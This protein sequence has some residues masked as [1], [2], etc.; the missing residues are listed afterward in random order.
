MKTLLTLVFI[1][2][3]CSEVFQ[4]SE[5]LRCYQCEGTTCDP[6]TVTCSA[7]EDTCQT[8]TVEIQGQKV[9][10]KG[11]TTKA[12]CDAAAVTGLTKCC[13][14]D[15]CNGAAGVKLSFLLVPLISSILF[16]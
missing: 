12:I 16:L 2:M 15:L 4:A 8:T 6:K 10:A 11:C 7:S 1:Y 3:L 13:Q 5:A 9:I 14:T